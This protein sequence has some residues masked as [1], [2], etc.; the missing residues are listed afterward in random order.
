M[1][2]HKFDG[3]GCGLGAKAGIKTQYSVWITN[4]R[5][6]HAIKGATLPSHF[7]HSI[8]LLHSSKCLLSLKE[9]FT[10][11]MAAN[12][13]QVSRLAS[14]GK[15]LVGGQIRSLIPSLSIRCVVRFFF[16]FELCVFWCITA[17]L[18]RIALFLCTCL[19][20]F[21]LWF[22]NFVNLFP[23]SDRSCASVSSLKN[24]YSEFLITYTI[25]P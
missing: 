12:Y 17:W 25:H 8:L 10:I 3:S 6:S 19:E 15:R 21:R 13:L 20:K 4:T 24:S 16:F 18:W 11:C 22:L 1:S 14:F 7:Q 23:L 5:T 2:V 9:S